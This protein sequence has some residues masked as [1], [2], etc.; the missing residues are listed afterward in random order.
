[1]IGLSNMARRQICKSEQ[2]ENEGLGIRFP[3]P[4]LGEQ[5]TGFLIRSQGHAFAYVN[6]CAHVPVELDWNQ[7]EFFETN[8]QYLV[9]ATHGALYLPNSGKCIAGPCAGKR[10]RPIAVFEQSGMIEID[11]DFI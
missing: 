11:L 2:L 1:M 3:L 10:L 5:V 7:G 6:Q 9:C 8:K 4:E